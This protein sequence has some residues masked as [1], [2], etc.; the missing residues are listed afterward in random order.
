MAKILFVN[1]LYNRKETEINQKRLNQ[2]LFIVHKVN[3]CLI[4]LF[5]VAYWSY[6]LQAYYAEDT[7]DN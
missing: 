5:V 1:I 6:G 7:A 2:A 3:P 4:L